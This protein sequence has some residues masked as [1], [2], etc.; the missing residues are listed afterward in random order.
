M[1]KGPTEDV[2]IIHDFLREKFESLEFFSKDDLE[3]IVEDKKN[4][5]YYFSKKIVPL[6]IKNSAS[7]FRVSEYFRR[8]K[9]L[10]DFE[11]HFS[12]STKVQVEYTP[13][14]RRFISFQFFLPLANELILRDSLD[15]LFYSDRIKR[16]MKVV[17]RIELEECFP[18]SGGES[19]D[20][21]IDRV[22]GEIAIIFGGYS[23]SHVSG[24]FRGEDIMDFETAAEKIKTDGIKYLYD[25]TTAVIRFIIPLEIENEPGKVEKQKKVD[26][27]EVEI[28]RWVFMKI[29]VQTI[30]ES[31]SGEAEIWLLET[32]VKNRLYSWQRS[33]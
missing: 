30:L 33:T 6:L 12:Q 4:F 15:S 24:R 10:G 20:Q 32:G 13:N 1:A 31:V 9:K 29:F 25:E 16:R 5:K 2:K 26:L 27:E 19:E 14:E 18:K 23:V 7:E 22:I 21:Y 17:D 3:A 11:K 28:I 8:L